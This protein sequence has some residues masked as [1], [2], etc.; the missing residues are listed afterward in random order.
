M[1]AVLLSIGDEILIG[2]I[3]NTNSVWLASQ[4][5]RIGVHVV[6]MMTV[7]DDETAIVDALK[8]SLSKSEIII[9]TGGLGPTRDDLTKDVLTHFFHT[10]LVFNQQVY[11]LLNTFFTSRGMSFNEP[12]KTQC[13]VPES[14]K[15]MMNY[16]GTA[17]GMLF[18][19]NHKIVASMPGVPY[20]MEAMAE[21]EL[22]PYL[23]QHFQMPPILHRTFLT[24]GIPESELMIRL[25]DW[26]NDLPADLKLAYLPSGGQVR[27]R[28][29]SNNEDGNA[30][31][32]IEN[33]SR[34]LH[35]ILDNEI[36]GYD[37]DSIASVVQQ[38]CIQHGKTLVTAESCT[39]GFIAHQL[40]MIPGASKYF[41]GSIVA[42][43]N[44]IKESLLDVPSDILLEFGAVSE[45]TV[46][47]MAVSARRIMKADYAIAVSGIAGPEGGS[48]EKP[49]GTV[50]IAWASDEQTVARKFVWGKN[51]QATIQRTAQEALFRFRRFVLGMDL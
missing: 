47:Q 49:V 6:E 15:V 8:E 5:N 14:C 3:T 21:G 1:K 41:K 19:E 25:F 17:P 43:H 20:E 26:E 50:W 33:A 9:I 23:R 28:L 30:L 12:N 22:F 45:Q 16:K 37:E 27:L 39:G 13:Y 29:T 35:L 48:P 44:T 2:Q 7:G 11:D 34:Y 38:L 10:R 31:E 36:V 4:L 42:Y 46:I 40:T 32:R 24:G 18:H 51:R